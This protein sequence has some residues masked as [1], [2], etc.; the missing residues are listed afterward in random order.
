MDAHTIVVVAVEAD[1]QPSFRNHRYLKASDLGRMM[2]Q[3]TRSA[4]S[5]TTLGRT[6]TAMKNLILNSGLMV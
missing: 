2:S 1:A 5:F 6:R 3:K 4:R